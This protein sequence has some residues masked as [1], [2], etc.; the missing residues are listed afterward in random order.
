[1]HSYSCL[2]SSRDLSLKGA[3]ITRLES[4]WSLVRWT[5]L[6]EELADQAGAMISGSVSASGPSSG[7]SR[8]LGL[9]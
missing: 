6:T 9:G 4:I 7:P 8:A 1:M 3:S 5:Y 2:S